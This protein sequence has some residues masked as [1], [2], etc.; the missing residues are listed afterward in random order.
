MGRRLV[1]AASRSRRASAWL[2]VATNSPASSSAANSPGQRPGRTPRA[3]ASSYAAARRRPNSATPSVSTYAARA[4]SRRDACSAPVSWSSD[5]AARSDDGL[6][7]EGGQHRA[8]A[9]DVGRPPLPEGRGEGLAAEAVRAEDRRQQRRV[10]IAGVAQ[11]Q[12]DAPTRRAPTPP[13]SA[14]GPPQGRRPHRAI[15]ASASKHP[16]A[17][18]Q[19]SQP[20]SGW[21]RRRAVTRDAVRPRRRGRRGRPLRP[22]SRHLLPV[23][24]S[25]EHTIVSIRANQTH[26][27]YS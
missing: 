25:Y 26:T 8:G 15:S 7:G 22:P 20:S 27:S 17:A 1:R 6:P 9:Q 3:F 24:R 5:R 2:A 13:G 11:A 19:P 14:P 21:A 23:A 4:F 10:Q 12:G 16:P 18:S